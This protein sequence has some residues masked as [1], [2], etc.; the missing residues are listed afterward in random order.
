MAVLQTIR[1][2]FVPLETSEPEIIVPAPATEYEIRPLTDKNLNEVLRLNFRCFSNGE[3]YTKHTFNYLLSEPRNLSYRIVTASGEMVGFVFVLVNEDGSAH[4]TTIGVAPE[5]RRRN[6]AKRLLLHLEDALRARSIFT[7]V[8]EV[9]VSN[10][11]AQNLYRAAGY[12]V[13]QRLAKYY[14]NGEDCFLMVKSLS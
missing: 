11:S 3:N 12:S 1:N 5:H 7:V 9:R 2:F 13:V 4:L 10:T 14:N 8:L 6:L